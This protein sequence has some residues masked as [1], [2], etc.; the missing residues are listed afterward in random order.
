MTIF[1][2]EVIID[3]WT[4]TDNSFFITNVS[5]IYVFNIVVVLL[6]DTSGK[7]KQKTKLCFH[8]HS[9]LTTSS[10]YALEEMT[11]VCD[12]QRFNRIVRFKEKKKKEGGREGWILKTIIDKNKLNQKM[13][14]IQKLLDFEHNVESFKSSYI[15]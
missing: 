11:T 9:S 13:E 10:E 14:A 15:N 4:Y 5:K 12:Y 7:Q 6:D 3:I 1:K 2:C 8:H